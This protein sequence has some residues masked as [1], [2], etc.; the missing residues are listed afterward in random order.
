MI[1]L[2]YLEGKTYPEIADIYECSRSRIDQIMKKALRKLQHPLG[3]VY[4]VNGCEAEKSKQGKRREL[5]K[6]LHEGDPNERRHEVLQQSIE[7]LLLSIRS[8]NALTRSGI[9]TINDLIER[10]KEPNWY[11]HCRNL[12]RMSAREVVTKMLELGIIDES[13]PGVSLIKE[14]RIFNKLY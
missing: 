7:I 11:D 6:I 3:I 1:L 12:G 10:A 14:D 2:R 4:I 13:H 5:L 9:C 8:Y